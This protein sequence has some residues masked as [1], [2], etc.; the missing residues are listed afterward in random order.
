MVL[1]IATLCRLL[2]T[3][4]GLALYQAI[5]RQQYASNNSG[6]GPSAPFLPSCAPLPCAVYVYQHYQVLF[7][8]IFVICVILSFKLLLCSHLYYLRRYCC[9]Y[10]VIGVGFCPLCLSGGCHLFRFAGYICQ[11]VIQVKQT[12]PMFPVCL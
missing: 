3:N 1:S 6:P 9:A 8:V 12:N 7:V 5:G 10:V 2:L 4:L 11:Y